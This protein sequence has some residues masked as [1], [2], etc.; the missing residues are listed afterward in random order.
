MS[1]VQL[2]SQMYH[3]DIAENGSKYRWICHSVSNSSQPT[4]LL[5]K[6]S[7]L[8]HFYF[9]WDQ[10]EFLCVGNIFP[11]LVLPSISAILRSTKYWCAP[12]LNHTQTITSS[13]KAARVYWIWRKQ[14]QK[15]SPR[16]KSVST[17]VAY[18]SHKT[19]NGI[20]LRC[21]DNDLLC[22]TRRRKTQSTIKLQHHS[23]LPVFFMKFENL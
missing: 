3:N 23:K 20:T 21:S 2:P 7:I 4:T 17:G 22:L 16:I 13:K 9:K 8:Q 12:T 19:I 18:N 6:N 1:L 15:F 11:G 14:R 5:T 10:H